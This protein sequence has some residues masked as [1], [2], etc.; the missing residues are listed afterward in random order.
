MN[1]TKNDWIIDIE[2]TLDH[3]KIRLAG[4]HNPCQEIT[5]CTGDKDNFHTILENIRKEPKQKLWFWNGARFD[6]PVLEEVWNSD[7]EGFILQDGMHLAQIFDHACKRKALDYFSQRFFNEGKIDIEPYTYDTIPIDKLEEYL[8]RD[9]EITGKVIDK[10]LSSRRID[11]DKITRTLQ[12]EFRVAYLCE[13]QVKKGVYFDREQAYRTLG[14]IV[15]EMKKLE[16]SVSARLPEWQLPK[17]K[18]VQV[19]KVQFKKDGSTTVAIQ[20]Y[21]KKLGMAI[22]LNKEGYYLLDDTGTEYPLPI[23]GPLVTTEKLTLANTNG[24]KEWLLTLGWKPT[25]WNSNPKGERTGPRLT[26]RDS[27]DP[28]PN[29]T[30]MG[31]TF[32]EEYAQWLTLRHRKNLLNSD[33]GAGWLNYLSDHKTDF[34]PS[35]ADTMGANT[36]RWTHRIIANVP[37]PTSVY[38]EEIRSMFCSREHL[39]WVGWDASALEARVEAHYCYKFDKA[40]AKELC[41]GDV[42][43]RNLDLIPSLK[44]RDN[45]KKFKYAITYGAQPAKLARTF[46]WTKAEATEI[47]N[48]FWRQNE[49]LATVKRSLVEEWKASGRKCITGLD[50]RPISTRSEHSLL[51]ALFQSAGAIIMKYAMVIADKSIHR[52]YSETEAYGLIRYHDEEVWEASP[53]VAIEV[54]DLGKK[55][56]PAAGTY[57]G[58]NVPLEAEVK[59]G[60]NW[61][62]VH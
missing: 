41:E 50:G 31:Y 42:H 28:C 36:G 44:T 53:S 6:V 47:Y 17:S 60:D 1:L 26:L 4:V 59:I 58:L 14:D 5:W 22:C 45:A 43:R 3:K 23:K 18:I 54:A 35:D 40:Y 2:T 20:N 52:E 49:A 34:L 24:I 55:S 21:A 33:N 11:L 48:E 61:A 8:H 19:P 29:L 7:L 27:G 25:E 51:N 32:V 30:K 37:R 62:E 16:E 38:G 46:G 9:L 39:V 13:K 57:L 10:M 15:S 12:L 56:I